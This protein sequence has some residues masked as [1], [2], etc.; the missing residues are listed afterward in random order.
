M[1]VVRE[2]ADYDTIRLDAEASSGS[3]DRRDES[4]VAA[5]RCDGSDDVH[6]GNSLSPSGAH[7]TRKSN[8]E[9]RGA[10]QFPA[11]AVGAGEEKLQE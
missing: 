2:G 8:E 6:G 7:G 4:T 10:L 9:G 11:H 5:W 1:L 3:S